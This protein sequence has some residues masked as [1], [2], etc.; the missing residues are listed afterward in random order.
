V[1]PEVSRAKFG[2]E[3][4]EYQARE[5]SYRARGWLLLDATFPTVR[6]VMCAT[7]LTPPAVISGI[8]FDFTNYDEWPPSV[9]LID[10]FTGKPYLFG[11]MPTSLKRRT[12]GPPLELPGFVGPDGQ[13]PRLAGEQPLMQASNPD[14]VPFLCLA[15]VREYHDHPAHSG[16][17]WDLYRDAGAGRLLRLLEVIDTYGVRPISDY[18]VELVPRITG[19]VQSE[20]PE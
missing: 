2:R 14:E 1:D 10:P 17:S 4:A 19:F 3:V 8:E 11:A 6:V 9:R 16:D 15:G 20:V 13:G 12:F 7:R 18:N 5:A